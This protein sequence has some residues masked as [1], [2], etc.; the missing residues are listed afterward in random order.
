M[1]CCHKQQNFDSLVSETYFK[2]AK[3]DIDMEFRMISYDHDMTNERKQFTDNQNSNTWDNVTD[4][5]GLRATSSIMEPRPSF[6]PS[7]SK[8]YSAHNLGYIPEV[9]GHRSTLL[10]SPTYAYFSEEHFI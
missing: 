10:N 6:T 9:N 3:N 7:Q 4:D 5:D 2:Q 8:L 1:L